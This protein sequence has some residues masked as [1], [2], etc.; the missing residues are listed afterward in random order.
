M[1]N[2]LRFTISMVRAV[3]TDPIVMSLAI[4]CA[5]LAVVAHSPVLGL[6]V[7]FI[8]YSVQRTALQLAN[9]AGLGL[10]AVARELHGLVHKK[11]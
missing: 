9:A 6:A 8:M 4:G 11:S 5:A 3:L 10:Q 1:T 7:F 2:P